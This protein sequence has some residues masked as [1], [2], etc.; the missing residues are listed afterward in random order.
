M[1]E[2]NARAFVLGVDTGKASELD[3]IAK[4]IENEIKKIKNP[5]AVNRGYVDGLNTALNIVKGEIK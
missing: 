5:M 2:D 4:L 1:N 3:R